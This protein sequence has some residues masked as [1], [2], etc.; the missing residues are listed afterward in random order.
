MRKKEEVRREREGEKAERR[1]TNQT[2]FVNPICEPLSRSVS[3]HQ[4]HIIPDLS[5]SKDFAYTPPESGI[6]LTLLSTATSSWSCFRAALT[7][8]AP[9]AAVRSSEESSDRQS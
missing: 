6:L 7:E 1:R 3:H 2:G 4:H 5:L 9:D 8:A